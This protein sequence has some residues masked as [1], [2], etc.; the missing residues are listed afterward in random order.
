MA[1]PNTTTLSAAVGKND[2][3]VLV[4]AVTNVIAGNL[5]QIDNE[6]MKIL[7]VPAAATTPVPVLRGQEGTAQVSH[8]AT[9]QVLLGAN[10]SNL[11]SGDWGQAQAGAVSVA[12]KPT[13]RTRQVTNYAAAGAITLPPPG[14]DGVAILDGTSTLAMTLANPSVLNDGDKLTIIANGKAAHTVTYT[15]GVGNGGSTMDVGTFNT[16]EAAGC[17]LMAANGFWVLIANG[18]GS[19]GTQVAGVVFA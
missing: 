15:A 17:E 6:M 9:A 18:I 7:S 19:A 8:S 3:T 1:L 5:L 16:T 2:T 4:A 11:V 13:V 14:S 12:T 10:P